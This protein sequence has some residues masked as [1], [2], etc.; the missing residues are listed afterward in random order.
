MTQVVGVQ[1]PPPAPRHG[2]ATQRRILEPRGPRGR[3]RLHHNQDEY[4]I[5]AGH[6]NQQRRPQARVQGGR[7]GGR[8]RRAA[9]R[10]PGEAQGPRPDSRLPARQGAGRRTSRRSMAAPSMAETIEEVV[11]ETNAKIV[12]DHGF[13]LAMDPKI[14]MPESQSEIEGIIAGK[15]DLAYTVAL[16]VVPPITLADFKQIS[17]G[18]ADRRGHRRRGR[19]GGRQDRRAEPAVRPEGRGRQG[20]DGRPGHRQVHRHHRRPAVR[21]RQRRRHRGAGRLEHLHSGLRG[22]ARSGWRRARPAPSMSRFPQNYLAPNLAGKAAVFEVTAKS[23]ETPGAVT[24]DDEFA[25]SLGMESLDKLKGAIRER[26]TPRARVREPPEAQA[27]AARRARQ[28]AQVRS[29]ADPGRGGVQ[30]RVGHGPV[31]PAVAEP[32][33]RGRGHDRGE[34][35]RGIPRHRGPPRAARPGAGGDRRQEQHQ[36]RP[37]TRSRGRSSSRRASI[38]AA[39]RRSGTTTA[40][41]RTRS[42]R[43][44]APIFEE[45]VVDFIVE[46]AKVTD[47]PVSREELFKEDEAQRP[48]RP[49]RRSAS[50]PAKAAGGGANRGISTG[51]GGST[52]VSARSRHILAPGCDPRG[53]HSPIG[54]ASVVS[55]WSQFQGGPVSVSPEGFRRTGRRCA[56]PST[57]T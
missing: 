50:G 39:S 15:S 3:P 26:L 12:T 20:R 41:I 53:R 42:R 22:A 21:G 46:L 37:T 16:E 11:R 28:A 19:R 56:I 8:S 44:R 34:G 29:A 13:K 18:A 10:P 47:K 23:I 14:T 38:P 40:R 49:R 17:A 33:L 31:R 55:I 9:Q 6:R 52:L 51:G 25:K 45:K 57:P 48:E 32:H 1:V 27:H 2:A 43:L 54:P 7:A 35:A 36:G 30:Q 24:V 5:H 4:L